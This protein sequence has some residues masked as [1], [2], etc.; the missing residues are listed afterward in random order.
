MQCKTTK[1][2]FLT[3]ATNITMT[4]STTKVAHQLQRAWGAPSPLRPANL[5]VQISVC[6]LIVFL[7]VCNCICLCCCIFVYVIVF[8][9]ML[10]CPFL[11]DLLHYCTCNPKQE[12]QENHLAPHHC[13]AP[14]R[15]SGKQFLKNQTKKYSKS[16]FSTQMIVPP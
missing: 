1:T 7:C 13:A 2:I 9:C 15:G 11:F 4:M 12:N 10:L 14:I 16:D 8:L 6:P 3:T 5:C